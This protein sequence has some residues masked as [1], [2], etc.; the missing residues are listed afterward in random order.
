LSI[1]VDKL[2][3]I[4]NAGWNVAL[5]DNL[6]HDHKEIRD[7]DRTLKE[8]ILKSIEVLEYRQIIGGES[9]HD[10]EK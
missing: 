2:K 9:T 7:K 3:S 6:W 5:D 4:L 8:L 1:K 10:P